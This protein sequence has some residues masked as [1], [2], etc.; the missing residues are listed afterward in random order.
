M[1]MSCR[2]QDILQGDFFEDYFLLAY[3]SLTWMLWSKTKCG[4]VIQQYTY[5]R[6]YGPSQVPWIVK[7]DDD[8]INN[9]WK[10]GALVEALKFQRWSKTNDL[11]A[12]CVQA[13]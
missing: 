13:L 6:H 10:L 11:V 4:K 8:M 2:Y 9:I 7:T 3:K 5:I 12:F 1:F